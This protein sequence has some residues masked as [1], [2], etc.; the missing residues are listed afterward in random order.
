[1]GG[2]GI[3]AGSLF[4]LAFRLVSV[5]LWAAIGVL[6]ARTLSVDERGIYAQVVVVTSAVG[7]ISS[8]SAA[9]GYFVA[10]GGRGAAEVSANGALLGLALG[11]VLLAAAA[12][13]YIVL[14]NSTGMFVLLGGLA[15]VP[16]ILRQT[17]Q[18]VLLGTGELAKFNIAANAPVFTALCVLVVWLWLLGHRSAESAVAAWAVAQ[19]IA[20]L[21]MLVWSRKGLG[22][23]A[24]H[25]PDTDL[26]KG[27]VR[28]SAVI[29]VGGVVGL[30]NSR[31]DLLLVGKLDSSHSAGIYASALGVSEMLMLFSAAMAIATYPRM[32]SPD[33]AAAARLTATGVRHTLMVV[34]PGG[35]VAAVFAPTAIELLF[36]NRY[37]EAATPLRILCLGTALSA[38][39]P[40]LG[41]YFTVQ[42]GRPGIVV[43]LAALSAGL[44]IVLGLA[45]IPRFGEV[46]AAWATTLGSAVGAGVAVMLFCA[47]SGL[48]PRELWQIRR[49][50]V[51]SY[52]HLARDVASG[53][54][55]APA[56]TET[57]G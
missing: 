23:L 32:G 28:F 21:P 56:R 54:A 19:G 29:G 31:V 41:N 35:I 26:A 18:G 49:S 5:A 24:T 1:M 6:T 51:A 15:V 25:R 40:L 17:L 11:S 13:G 9:T 52:V 7:G 10:K 57:P 33:P 38:A 55:F 27:I 39:G 16:A 42:L 20:L 47:L 46:G 4:A 34:I 36:G 45:L 2:M 43:R 37:A 53:R 12:G 30:L 14:G 22:W 8:F 48:H 50:D 3:A 44:T